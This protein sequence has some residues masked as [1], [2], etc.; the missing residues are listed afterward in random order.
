MSF[1]PPAEVSF[2]C[3]THGNYT[4]PF[5][6]HDI[7]EFVL[8]R[9]AVLGC[10]IV[11]EQDSCC[12][13]RIEFNEFSETHSKKASISERAQQATA[14]AASDTYVLRMLCT[15]YIVC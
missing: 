15:H 2:R 4:L 6:C 5:L 12:S 3:K 1:G 13:C 11:S 9:A 8:A 10:Y 14:D 7:L